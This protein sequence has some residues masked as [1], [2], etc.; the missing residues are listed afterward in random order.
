M[1][2]VILQARMSS[3]RLPGKV[4]LPINGH[5]MIYWQIKR[6]QQ[7][8]EISKIVVA[9]S[10]HETDNQLSEYLESIN[11]ETFRGSMTDVHSRFLSV[12]ENHPECPNI[13]RLTGDCPF[14][15][16]DVLREII[17]DFCE[18]NLDYMSNSA[19]PTFPDGLD[20]EIFS[21]ESFL[22][23]SKSELTSTHREHVTLK[24]LESES[25]FRVGHYFN[26]QDLSDFR[27]T[28]DYLADYNFVRDVFE[29]LQGREENFT[30]K[31]VLALLESK[32]ELNTQLS[33]NLRN[34]AL[35]GRIDN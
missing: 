6:I 11:I 25:I 4:L 19:Q 18:S 8:E 21:R 32:P 22:R 31:D 1:N 24:Y 9:T 27:W 17:R 34:I 10:A 23:L 16:P 12:I 35:Q 33:P 29:H 30:I 7:V 5:P 28:V 26:D 20:V 14:T 15:M 3:S 2:L 13:I